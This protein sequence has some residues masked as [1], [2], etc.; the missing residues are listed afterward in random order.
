[1]AHVHE[2]REN[3]GEDNT[4]LNTE[5]DHGC[6]GDDGQDKFA[7]SGTPNCS[8]SVRVDQLHANQ[9]YDR[10]EYGIREIAQGP[11]QKQKDQEDN[12]GCRDVGLPL[13]TKVLLQP[14]IA[15]ANDKPT[16]SAF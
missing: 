12:S 2:Q 8:H 9:E 1:M 15:L 4:L 6:S 11:G 14:A 5:D 3:H 10:G 16:R 13:T 7:G